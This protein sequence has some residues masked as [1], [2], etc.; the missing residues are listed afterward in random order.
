MPVSPPAHLATICRGTALEAVI[1]G[2]VAV[3]GSAGEILAAAGDPETVT[4]LRSCAK[5]VQALPLVRSGDQLALTD[6]EVA[7]AC[8]S[9]GGEPVHVAVVRRLL[10]RAGL[11]DD[12]LLCGPQLPMD[13][14]SAED[15][16]AAGGRA[17]AITNNC[18][19]KHAGM[20]AVCV[21][22]GWRVADYTDFDHP[23]QAEIRAIMTGLAGVD[24]DSAPVGI[25]GCGLP[26]HGLPLAALARMFGAAAAEPA[27]RRCQDAMATHPHMVA[28]RGRF[29]TAILSVAGSRL[30]VKGGA[31]GVWVAARRPAGPGL[32][33]KL[34][35]GDQF[36][37]SAVA[38]A[39]LQ[40]LGWL[41]E[42]EAADPR[43]AGFAQPPVR[44]WAGADVGAI[45]AEPGWAE[46]LA[47]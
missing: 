26:T 39:A 1:R 37:M 45:T 40:H 41:S 6:E 24:V 14:P 28:G 3:V 9:H 17:A 30:T 33:I 31:A 5:P 18:S 34:E 7:V 4:T 47:R 42:A 29:D 35:G 23:L 19:G 43:L 38:L 46:S 15:I 2:H 11:D 12:A 8:A 13:D 20:L 32:A 44:N 36:A 27:F 16:L 25:D 21:A 10:G 22:R